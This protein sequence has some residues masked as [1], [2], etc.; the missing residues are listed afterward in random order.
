MA[1]GGVWRH[2]QLLDRFPEISAATSSRLQQLIAFLG[3]GRNRDLEQAAAAQGG[4]PL[5]AHESSVGQPGSEARV[6]L[7][8]SSGHSD[9]VG[10]VTD[11]AISPAEAGCCLC[12]AVASTAAHPSGSPRLTASTIVARLGVRCGTTVAR[13][14][15]DG[16]LRRPWNFANTPPTFFIFEY[17]LVDADLGRSWRSASDHDR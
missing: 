7:P 11:A 14:G 16:L 10:N 4:A 6:R 8:P 15:V 17:R 13:L 5:A 9:G 3:A 1:A 2:G 12:I